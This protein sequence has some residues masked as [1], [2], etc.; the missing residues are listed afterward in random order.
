MFNYNVSLLELPS[1]N[2]VFIT[3][4]IIMMMMMQSLHCL[5]HTTTSLTLIQR[6]FLLFSQY[7]VRHFVTTSAVIASHRQYVST[8][9]L[10]V[11]QYAVTLILSPYCLRHS[12]LSLRYN[13]LFV[14]V[15]VRFHFDTTSLLFTSWYAITLIQRPYC[16]RHGTPSL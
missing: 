10:F 7:A 11:S 12:T 4:I 15:T 13:A 6:P 14:N 9:V 1:E 8:S 3:I 2:K 5:R 16:L